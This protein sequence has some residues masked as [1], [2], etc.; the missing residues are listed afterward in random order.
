MAHWKNI[1]SNAVLFAGEAELNAGV[2][3]IS[4]GIG[5]VELYQEVYG[6]MPNMEICVDANACK[7][8]LLGTGSGRVTH[9]STKQL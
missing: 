4:E 5:L 9:F 3:G 2:K 8:M 6:N 7:G 1:Q